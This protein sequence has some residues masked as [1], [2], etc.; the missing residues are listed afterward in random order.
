MCGVRFYENT[1]PKAR[2]E[3]KYVLERLRPGFAF[4]Q[5][6][7]QC[8]LIGHGPHFTEIVNHF[9]KFLPHFREFSSLPINKQFLTLYSRSRGTFGSGH[10]SLLL[11]AQIS[12][13]APGTASASL[14][15][16]RRNKM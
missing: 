3:D 13:P 1:E 16:R 9:F 6:E 10:R 2:P 5:K 7:I 15:T 12:R 14:A 4:R 8:L 11:R